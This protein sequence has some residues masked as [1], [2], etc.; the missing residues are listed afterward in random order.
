MFS[1]RFFV[2]TFLYYANSVKCLP[3]L[4]PAW[5]V[6]SPGIRIMKFPIFWWSPF[7]PPLHSRAV[8]I[9]FPF[10]VLTCFFSFFCCTSCCHHLWAGL[11]VLPQCARRIFTVPVGFPDFAKTRSDFFYRTRAPTTFDL[12]V[13]ALHL[14]PPNFTLI[15]RTSNSLVRSRPFGILSKSKLVR[16]FRLPL[17]KTLLV[18]SLS[19]STRLMSIVPAIGTPIFLGFWLRDVVSPEQWTRVSL[20]T[21]PLELFVSLEQPVFPLAVPL[22]LV[23]LLYFPPSGFFFM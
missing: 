6:P 4:S 5:R 7:K 13:A 15:L 10:F 1:L 19:H 14:S 8:P 20:Y 2:F 3:G 18:F 23:P 16:T 21:T 11:N 12:E 22:E 17:L 9:S